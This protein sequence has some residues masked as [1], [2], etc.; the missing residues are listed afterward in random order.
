MLYGCNG[1]MQDCKM[2]LAFTEELNHKVR[3]GGGGTIPKSL[4]FFI[5]SQRIKSSDDMT[6]NYHLYGVLFLH[7]HFRFDQIKT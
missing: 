3:G 7:R 5:G 4:Q 1:H 6:G 2:Q